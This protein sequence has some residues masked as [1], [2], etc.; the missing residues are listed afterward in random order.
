MGTDGRR[1]HLAGGRGGG[2]RGAVALEPRLGERALA[3]GRGRLALGAGL[4][5]ARPGGRRLPELIWW[6]VRF[7]CGPRRFLPPRG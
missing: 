1:P 7:R 5:W 4:A 2:R 3:G 6:R